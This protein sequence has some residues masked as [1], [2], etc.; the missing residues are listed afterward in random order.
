MVIAEVP[1]TPDYCEAIIC[2]V[3][4]AW[5]ERPVEFTDGVYCGP[6]IS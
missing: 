6:E 3:V 4:F 1:D 5:P 2:A